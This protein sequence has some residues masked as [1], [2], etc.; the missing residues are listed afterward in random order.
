[1]ENNQPTLTIPTDSQLE[2][3]AITSRQQAICLIFIAY[4]LL[5]VAYSKK[6]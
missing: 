6:K 5:P 4:R 1:L 3:Q 2:K